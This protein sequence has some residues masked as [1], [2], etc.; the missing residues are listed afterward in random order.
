M[1]IQDLGLVDQLIF[2]SKSDPGAKNRFIYYPDR[3]NRLPSKV[4]TFFEMFELWRTGFTAGLFSLVRE[5]TQP[6]RSS[7][8]TDETIGH[9]IERRFDKRLAN[10]LVSAGIHGIYAGDI[11]QL[12]CKTLFSQ[13]WHLEKRYGSALGGF[14][15]M[16]TENEGPGMK[17]FAHPFDLEVAR[18]INEEVDLD[19]D[20]A[21]KLKAAS[22]YSFKDGLQQLVTTLQSSLEKKGNVE[23]RVNTP[24][25]SSKLIEGEAQQ[26]EVV[27][28]VCLLRLF[29]LPA[30]I[31]N[32]LNPRHRRRIST[33]SSRLSAIPPLHPTL[34]S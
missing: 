17:V 34:P 25:Q 3:L 32:S 27:S 29:K 23:I 11:W 16:Q 6:A 4:P 5:P 21:K 26:V 2:T 20:F 19:L 15:R 28:G 30:L 33:W 10:N 1:Q 14:F 8:L 9:F 22:V 18:A 12:S 31:C 13:A 7:A 24:V